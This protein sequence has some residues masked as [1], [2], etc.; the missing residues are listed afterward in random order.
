MEGDLAFEEMGTERRG[1]VMPLLLRRE[2]DTQD[3][4]D[5]DST[6]T[7]K[8]RLFRTIPDLVYVCIHF[9]LLY[10]KVDYLAIFIQIILSG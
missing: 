10:Y 5:D 7:D 4:S 2:H 3:G 6:E 1:A 8:Y 9:L